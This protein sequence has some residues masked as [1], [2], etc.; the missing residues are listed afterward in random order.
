MIKAS[1]IPSLYFWLGADGEV[2]TVTEEEFNV[3]QAN[4]RSDLDK[5]RNVD[6]ADGW[7]SEVDA[8]SDV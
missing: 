5:W 6:R 4:V 2:E 3:K 7:E 1:D 8:G